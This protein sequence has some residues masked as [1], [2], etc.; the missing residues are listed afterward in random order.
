MWVK[1]IRKYNIE[2]YEDGVLKYSGPSEEAPQEIKS[3][4][5][6]KIDFDKKVIKIEV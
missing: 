2:V 4:E 6:K 5:T 1:E 3:R